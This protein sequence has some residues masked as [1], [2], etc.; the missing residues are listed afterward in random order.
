M[1]S[2]RPLPLIVAACVSAVEGAFLAGYAVYILIQVARLGITGPEP[3]SNPV[4]VTLEIVIFAV[5]GAGLLAAGWGLWHRRRWGRAP[6][7]LGQLLCLVVAVPLAGAVGGVER[8]I[9]IV[10]S[11]T[12]VVAL[13]CLF[14]PSTTRALERE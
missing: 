1:P 6:A 10:A 12:A 5:I 9:G 13:V 7:V 8:T 3:V 4:S 2:Q 14:L 11:V